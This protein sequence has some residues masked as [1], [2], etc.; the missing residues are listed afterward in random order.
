MGKVTQIEHPAS[1]LVSSEGR[2]LGG[3]GATV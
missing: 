2:F 1:Y 3:K